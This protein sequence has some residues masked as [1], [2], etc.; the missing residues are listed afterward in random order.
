MAGR[1]TLKEQLSFTGKQS[2]KNSV[3]VELK[4]PFLN[5]ILN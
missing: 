5:L 2:V 1:V 4:S 3:A